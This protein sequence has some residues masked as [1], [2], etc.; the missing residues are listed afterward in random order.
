VSAPEAAGLTITVERQPDPGDADVL[1]RE[2]YRDLAGQGVPPEHRRPLACYLR[3]AA[4]QLAGGAEG[5]VR[6]D[7]LKLDKMW[8]RQ[9]LRGRGLG[10]R[11][12]GAFEDAGRAMGCRHSR[13]S[14]YSCQAPGFYRRLGY[15][16]LAEYP[17]YPPGYA[18]VDLVKHFPQPGEDGAGAP[19]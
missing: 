1:S 5:D 15:A 16:V 12:L 14:T 3:D 6:W 10:T 7:W 4:G 9:D 17:D 11:L 13:T 8:V 19:A 18:K 2:L